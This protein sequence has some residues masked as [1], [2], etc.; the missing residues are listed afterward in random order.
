[1][2]LQLTVLPAASV[3]V[4]FTIVVPNGKTEPD[5][6]LVTIVGIPQ[7]SLAVTIKLT[8]AEHEPDGAFTVMSGK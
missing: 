6:L 3:A 8:A 4:A 2:K 1:L 7:L 5:A